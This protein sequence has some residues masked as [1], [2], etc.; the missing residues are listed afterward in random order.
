[1]KSRMS[2]TSLMAYTLVQSVLVRAPS[3]SSHVIA[4]KFC[5]FKETSFLPGLWPW[6]PALTVVTTGL[7]SVVLSGN[8]INSEM[9]PLV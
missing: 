7:W 4:L 3:S 1:M 6:L 5:L 9:S 2:S 8:T